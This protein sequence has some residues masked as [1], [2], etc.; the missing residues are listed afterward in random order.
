MVHGSVAWSIGS[1]YT[2]ASW[3]TG[4]VEITQVQTVEKIVE[5]PQVQVHEVVRHV[6]KVQV[7]TVEKI[8]EVSA[9][10]G[11][12]SPWVQWRSQIIRNTRRTQRMLRR[13]IT[14]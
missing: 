13:K 5:V 1:R 14:T 10:R 2:V 11:R 8:V 9:W 12:S 3:T 6:P 4:T 7:Q